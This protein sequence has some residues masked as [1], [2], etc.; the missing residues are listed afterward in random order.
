[1]RFSTAVVALAVATAYAAPVANSDFGSDLEVRDYKPGPHGNRFNLT[2]SHTP[3]DKDHKR[4]EVE[5]ADI[6]A[7]D[8][9]LQAREI[10][11]AD[12]EADDHELQ[13]REIEPRQGAIAGAVVQVLTP[14]AS[15]LAQKAVSAAITASGNLI[16]AIKDWTNARE[17]FTK[18]TV[19]NMMKSKPAGYVGAVC[20]NVGYTNTLATSSVVSA[21]LTASAL[22]VDYDCFYVKKGNTFVNKGD[23]GFINLA[24]NGCPYTGGKMVC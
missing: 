1:M 4:D 16:N 19:T 24:V 13:A 12:I 18:T 14:I 23:G 21:K 20:C 2:K 8:F 15:D 7:D 10:E 9:E 11:A 3:K 6:E 22:H 5:A 17:T